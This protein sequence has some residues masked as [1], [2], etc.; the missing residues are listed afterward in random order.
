MGIRWEGAPRPWSRGDAEVGGT[1]VLGTAAAELGADEGGRGG[2]ELQLVQFLYHHHTWGYRGGMGWGKFLG[3]VYHGE[4]GG[5][6][7]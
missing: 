1:S 3:S 5:T 7:V 6:A 2:R 4:V